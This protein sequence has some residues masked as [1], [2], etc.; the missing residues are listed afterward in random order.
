M[1]NDDFV[2]RSQVKG[3]TEPVRT[4]AQDGN[5]VPSP[6]DLPQVCIG[7]DDDDHASMLKHLQQLPFGVSRTSSSSNSVLRE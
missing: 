7:D 5:E 2:S 3:R 6:H 1:F 4:S